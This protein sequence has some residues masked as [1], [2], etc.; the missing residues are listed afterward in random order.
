MPLLPALLLA[1]A[2]LIAAPG[3]NGVGFEQAKTDFFGEHLA[4]ELRSAGVKIV[5][6]KEI[7][8]LLGMERQRQLLGCAEGS[9]CMV[10]LANA[11][12]AEGV[13][14]GDLA[15]LDDGSIQVNLK[16]IGT[17]AGV[18]GAR[19]GRV[20]TEAQL[21]DALTAAAY[22]LARACFTM[23]RASEPAPA[24]VERD[25]RRA[26]LRAWSWVPSVV[27]VAGGAVGAVMLLQASDAH[28]Q[29]TQNPQVTLSNARAQEIA[30]SGRTSQLIGGIAVG[31]GVAGLA[32]AAAMFFYK[33]Q[34]VTL[35]AA[36]SPSGGAIVLSG[37][38]P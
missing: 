23:L 6:N 12:G 24:T 27:A 1:A 14:L 18:I 3:L 20:A 25:L 8:A 34:P 22:E 10:E 32:A 19:S 16:I 9:S 29:L 11:L 13:L 31:V 36:V 38:L 5:T 21:T 15:R 4:Q 35:Q 2:P 28:T 7:A 17:N 30:Q 33:E 26:P 37:A